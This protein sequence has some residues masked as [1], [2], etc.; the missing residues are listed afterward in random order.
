MLPWFVLPWLW[1]AM[2]WIGRGIKLAAGGWG[3]RR[4]AALLGHPGE[5]S[6]GCGGCGGG[7]MSFVGNSWHEPRAGAGVVGNA[8]AGTAPAV[9]RRYRRWPS[10]SVGGEGRP[11]PGG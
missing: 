3:S 2:E 10:D 6:Q 4:I 8:A 1:D 11:A 7:R 9:G 5:H